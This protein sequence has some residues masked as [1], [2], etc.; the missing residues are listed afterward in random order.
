[1]TPGK[2]E[3]F[4]PRP[5]Y[6]RKRLVVILHAWN[7]SLDRLRGLCEFISTELPD[8]DIDLPPLRLGLTSR[9]DLF[10]LSHRLACLIDEHWRQ[11]T[12][13]SSDGRGYDE[14][15]LI[16]HSVGATLARTI[17]LVALGADLQG[18]TSS[19]RQSM[20]WSQKL[21]RIIQFAAFNR[22]W[23]VSYLSQRFRAVG[24]GLA[25]AVAKI[26]QPVLGAHVALQL[27][28]GSC[29]INQMRLH[30]LERERNSPQWPVVIQLLGSRDDLVAPEDA[31]DLTTAKN[32]VYL[33]VPFSD[34]Y[35]VV[36][37]GT[38]PNATPREKKAA[39]NRR[40]V[41]RR[42]LTES[43]GSL[44][45]QSELKEAPEPDESIEQVVFVIHGIRDPGYWAQHIAR[46]VL[47]EAE[48]IDK[49]TVTEVLHPSYG[50]FGM[51]PFLR[52][53]SRLSKVTWFMEHYLLAKARFPK[54]CISYIGHSNGTY[55][56]TS[57]LER[58]PACTFRHLAFAGSVVRSRF[59]WS[60]YIGEAKETS[61]C[62]PEKT[63][64]RVEKVCNYVA[65]EDL[66]VA[67]F[68]NLFEMVGLS[69]LGGA[70]HRGF[71]EEFPDRVINFRFAP[72]GH[73]AAL[74][75]EFWGSLG[76]FIMTGVLPK[77]VE[78]Y[79]AGRQSR[80][81]RLFGSFPILAWLLAVTGAFILALLFIGV[82]SLLGWAL[83]EWRDYF[84]GGSVM[85]F[86]WVL[87]AILRRL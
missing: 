10:D 36:D 12:K 9:E 27:Y 65:T 75:E 24:F 63:L 11:R 23:E 4:P 19:T 74:M 61:S 1:M 69:D 18:S 64:R 55:L 16:G 32:F 31:I 15:F 58:Y 68:P 45:K 30:W 44:R 79:R 81:A 60:S 29:F 66:I 22:G 49:R 38:G 56:P 82:G 72:G 14:I 59:P 73:S 83:P 47:D 21:S 76:Q 50:Y 37:L 6:R 71:A 51:W 42:A 78:A 33:D 67:G 52:M 87:S 13:H 86:V 41:V 28:R 85:G 34:H 40:D 3:P 39:D 53:K 35:T 48:R 20:P 62:E 2:S 77:E 84:V 7:Q 43:L 8:W 80:A 70:G 5:S 25:R 57:A 46:T 54:A 17:Y 26:F